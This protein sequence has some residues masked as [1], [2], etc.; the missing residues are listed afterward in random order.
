M[1]SDPD[2]RWQPRRGGSIPHTE[3]GQPHT[4]TEAVTER[5][6]VGSA[7]S[8]GMVARAV[9][10]ADSALPEH[11]AEPVGRDGAP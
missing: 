3:A 2:T 9:A 11:L 4:G 1:E 5:L 8:E 10:V 7:V 6:A